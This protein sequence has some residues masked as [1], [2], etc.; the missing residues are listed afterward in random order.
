MP[1]L[2]LCTKEEGFGQAPVGR[3]IA[4][5]TEPLPAGS[6]LAHGMGSYRV[7]DSGAERECLGKGRNAV[8]GG[9]EPGKGHRSR[10]HGWAPL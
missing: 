8:A 3:R 1:R 4:P 6:G 7:A 2:L 9:S 10:C 5:G